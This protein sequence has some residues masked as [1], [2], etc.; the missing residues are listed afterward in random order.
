M[1][2]D[3]ARKGHVTEHVETPSQMALDAH[4]IGVQVGVLNWISITQITI[5]DQ[6]FGGHSG[7]DHRIERSGTVMTTRTKLRPAGVHRSEA[8]RVSLTGTRRLVGELGR[9]HPASGSA[10]AREPS[11]LLLPSFCHDAEEMA[12]SRIS[13]G[14]DHLGQ[15]GQTL[16][17]ETVGEHGVW[18]PAG[19]GNRERHPPCR[20]GLVDEQPIMHM[21]APLKD[22]RQT[23]VE[24]RVEPVRNNDRLQRI[25]EPWTR[26]VL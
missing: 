1:P 2:V 15:H 11:Q 12:E 17:P 24:Q 14:C 4:G 5:P 21:T 26:R 7:T 19:P 22:D 10:Q 20:S 6:H 25:H 9:S 16:R 8:L 23:L 13:R 3:G 18:C